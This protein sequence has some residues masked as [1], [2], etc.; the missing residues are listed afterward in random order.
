MYALQL[1]KKE[2]RQNQNN[3]VETLSCPIVVARKK[4]DGKDEYLS[5]ED[6]EFAAYFAYNLMEK[7]NSVN[8]DAM[9]MSKRPLN[10]LSF[11]YSKKTNSK[12]GWLPSNKTK[13]AKPK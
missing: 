9:L 4:S 10:C 6:P 5:P 3:L 1:L 12:V 11:V 8:H 2:I 13:P 7:Y